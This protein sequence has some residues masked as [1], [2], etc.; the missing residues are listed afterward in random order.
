LAK[1]QGEVEQAREYYS[2]ALS[3]FEGLRAAPYVAR[4]RAALE[5][6]GG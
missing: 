6:L 4:T 5:T 2:R 3:A 1:A